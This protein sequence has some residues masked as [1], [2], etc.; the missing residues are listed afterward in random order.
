MTP[1][2]L[3]VCSNFLR[4]RE[5]EFFI[6]KLLVRIHYIIEM[7]RWTGLAPWE[8]GFPFPG[9]LTSTFL[10]T[11]YS[12]VGNLRHMHTLTAGKSGHARRGQI[13]VKINEINEWKQKEADPYLP[14]REL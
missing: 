1:T 9:S 5:R 10:V 8:F 2:V 7:I 6:D 14:M 4:I 3:R 13:N 11:T 12:V